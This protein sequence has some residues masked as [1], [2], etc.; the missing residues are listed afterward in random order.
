MSLVEVALGSEHGLE[1]PSVASC[2]NL[3]TIKKTQLGRRRGALP[4]EDV[5][6]LDDALRFALQL[7]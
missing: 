6:R 3:T 2:D 7:D 1:R 4:F 5:A